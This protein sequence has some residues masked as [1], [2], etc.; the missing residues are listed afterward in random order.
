MSRTRRTK[1][2]VVALAVLVSGTLVQATSTRTLRLGRSSAGE[3]SRSHEAAAGSADRGSDL[4][5]AEQPQ[6]AARP[7]RVVARPAHV[8]ATPARRRQPPRRRAAPRHPR[9]ARRS[10]PVRHGHAVGVTA[11]HYLRSLNGGRYDR[12]RMYWL[13]AQDARRNA[14]GRHVV[15]LDIGGQVRTGVYLSTTHRFLGYGRLTADLDAYLDGYHSRQWR[16]APVTI[17]VGTNND[18]LT[19]AESGRDWA[20]HVVNPL[21]GYA[22]RYPDMTVIGADD[23]EPGFGAG[24]PATRSWVRGYLAATRAPLL[25]NGSADGCSARAAFSRCGNGWSAG[26]VAWFAGSAAPGRIL[27]LPQIY[28]PTMAGQW[29][30]ISRTARLSHGPAPQIVGVLTENA[31]CA[32]DPTCPTMNS[33]AAWL[34]LCQDL[35]RA[36]GAPRDMSA[37]VDLDVR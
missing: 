11:G 34:T 37:I 27:V 26:D 21:I 35:V 16:Q 29:V 6:L 8:V 14:G 10:I 1:A 30:Q 18:L 32:G 13:G 7:A 20:V 9:P 4:P 15:L 24:V 5:G 25:D 12:P 28:N 33:R 22:A 19:S 36:R 17:A 31:A 23:I 3:H 2:I